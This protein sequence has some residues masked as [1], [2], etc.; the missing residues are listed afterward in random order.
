MKIAIVTDSNSGIFESEAK[1][2]GVYTLPMPFTVDGVCMYEG[3][4]LTQE[5]FFK[6]QQAGVEIT[7]SQPS[8]ADVVDL[9]DR[10][11]TEY[12]SLVYIPMTSGLS[13]SMATA[14]MLAQEYDGRVQVV[15]NKRISLPQRQSVLDAKLLA[16]KGLNAVQIKQRL[17]ETGSNYRIYLSVDTLKYLKKGG[18]IT[19]A[20]AAIG[21]V[22]NIKPV[23]QVMDT[24]ID[25]FA[26]VRGLH[27][28][29]EKMIDSLCQDLLGEFD[30]MPMHVGVA[31]SGDPENGKK[32]QKY[33]QERFPKCKVQS[34]PLSLSV[35][36]H[37]GPG[38]IGIGCFWYEE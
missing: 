2:L 34:A 38:A 20:A 30:G 26:K 4:D 31:Y 29:R 1:K 9:W 8:P 11:L 18:R 27:Q 7:S 14:A 35:A 17:E 36:C 37:T 22:L 32:W 21:T 16:K 6:K 33:V 24:G 25:A 3:V 10:L 13:G 28:A 19:P 23:L 5:E 15:D 12:D